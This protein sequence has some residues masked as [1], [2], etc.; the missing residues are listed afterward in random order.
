LERTYSTFDFSEI[1]DC[2]QFE[3]DRLRREYSPHAKPRADKVSDYNQL[4]SILLQL[5][6]VRT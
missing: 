2:V 1:L 3:V 6:K 5:Q 4:T